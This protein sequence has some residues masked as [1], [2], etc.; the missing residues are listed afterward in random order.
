MEG[1]P[2]PAGRA[3][4]AGDGDRPGVPQGA[5]RRGPAGEGACGPCCSPS[6]GTGRCA[7]PKSGGRPWPPSSSTIRPSGIWR[8]PTGAS[9]SC[10]GRRTACAS[11]AS[12]GTPL[13]EEKG[14][15]LKALGGETGPGSPGWT[16]SWTSWSTSAGEVGRPSL[17]AARRES[18]LS[19][20]LDS[21]DSA[22]DW[23]TWDMLG[24]GL[25]ATMAKHEH[26]GR[27]PGGHRLG[28]AVPYPASAP[29]WQTCGTWR[30]PGTDRG[31]FATFAD[32]FFDGFSRTGTSSP[33]STTRPAGV[34]AVDSR[35]CEVLNRLQWMDQKL[36]EEQDGLKRERESL[37]R[38]SGSD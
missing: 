19:A 28:P 13:L 9:G 7:C 34:E 32:Y 30:F 2:G 33:G 22:E 8:I 38:S 12:G 23:G 24:G 21:L 35:V 31:E 17:P 4:P 14:E 3:G 11:T 1:S 15:L 10:C 25:M 6:P 18:A 16:S 36:A 27:R 26:P 37:L 5:G 20:V 29:S